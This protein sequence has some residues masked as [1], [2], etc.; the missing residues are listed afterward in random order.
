MAAGVSKRG[1]FLTGAGHVLGAFALLRA[2]GVRA[3]VVVPLAL[4]IAL[5][6]AAIVGASDMLDYLIAEYL[7]GWPDFLQW[8]IWLLFALVSAV[9]VFFT[10]SIV[11]NILAS[12]F[13]GLLSEAVERHLRGDIEA[14]PFAWRRLL[15]ELRRTLVAEAR[16]LA[17]IVLRALPLL[18]IS[19]I[20]GLNVAGS[21]LWPLFGA[22]MLCMEYLDCPLGNH[23]EAF[24][25]V[26][27]HMRGA[28][29]LSLGFGFAMTVV[30][31]VPILNFIAVPLG[32]AA[33][34]RLYC[35]QIAEA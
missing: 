21:V 20:P 34:T 23:G 14:V 29:G 10:F 32:V 30:T 15:A 24:P 13:N 9:L 25:R 8:I 22:W 19:I 31:I 33:A 1:G 28:R 6:I 12:P 18:V 17:Y 35:A 27:E 3:Y 5:F 16:K 2:P 4:N 26:I 11:A 7:G